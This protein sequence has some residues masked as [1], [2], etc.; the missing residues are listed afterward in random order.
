MPEY[1]QRK[2]RASEIWIFPDKIVI[3]PYSFALQTGE[4]CPESKH[5][6]HQEYDPPVLRLGDDRVPRPRGCR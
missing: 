3:I 2:S 1:F 5:D 6:E 4:V